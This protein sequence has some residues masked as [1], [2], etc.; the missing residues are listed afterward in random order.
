MLRISKLT[1]YATV[2]LGSLATAPETQRTASELAASTHVAGPT[3]SKLLK[4]LQRAQ[5]VTSVR[6][7]KGGY[8]L[9]R[10]AEAINGAQ[11]LDALEGPLAL[12]A[13]ARKGLA[14]TW[15]AL[16]GRSAWQPLA[17]ASGV[18]QRSLAESRAGAG[19]ASRVYA[20]CPGGEAPK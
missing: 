4:Q 1:D 3:V 6:G 13:C 9:A 18:G 11:I 19:R 14:A 7:L 16:P 10:P 17:S 8:R 15:M 5:L 2:I 12:T 20:E